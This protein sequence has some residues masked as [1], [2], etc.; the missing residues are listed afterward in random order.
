[1]P[2]LFLLL[3]ALV[4]RSL[5][6]PGAKEPYTSTGSQTMDPAS[7]Y[8]FTVK[9]EDESKSKLSIQI[10]TIDGTLVKEETFNETVN[11]YK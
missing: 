5:T 7:S 9:L 3:V 11:P 1:M 4:F 8:K 10:T 6:L 2:A